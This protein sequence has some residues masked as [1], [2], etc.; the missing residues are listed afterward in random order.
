MTLITN[1]NGHRLVTT[2]TKMVRVT[3]LYK[4][5]KFIQSFTEASSAYLFASKQK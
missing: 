5:D 2:K 3:H 4:G 1:C